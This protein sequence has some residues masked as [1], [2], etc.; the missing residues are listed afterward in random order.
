M[1]TFDLD[2]A[3]AAR[4]H[5]N[6]TP[7]RTPNDFTFG[8]RTFDLPAILPVRAAEALVDKGSVAFLRELLGDQW[9]DF[10]AV[11]PEPDMDDVMD[12][13]TGVARMYALG[14]GLPESPASGSPSETTGSPSRPTSNGSTGA[15]SDTAAGAKE[16]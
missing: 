14:G 11:D 12:L 9:A 5:A 4:E 8:H 13:S 3:R 2:A 1:G 7:N 16:K 10:K 6:A 15:I